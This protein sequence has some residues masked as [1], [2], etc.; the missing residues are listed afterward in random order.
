MCRSSAAPRDLY[1]ATQQLLHD[2]AE[3]TESAEAILIDVIRALVRLRD[4]RMKRLDQLRAE[5]RS[6]GEAVELSAAEV[7]RLI[8]EQLAQ[9]HSSRVLVLVVAAA[10]QSASKQF[11][12][13]VLPLHGHNAADRQTGALGDVEITLAQRSSAS[14][15]FTR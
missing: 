3:G 1:A 4:E 5:L 7:A 2:V 15:P 11:G 8:G 14:P 12:E 13:R 10:H 9:P 6:A